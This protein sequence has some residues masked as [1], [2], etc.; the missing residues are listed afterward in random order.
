M[1]GQDVSR[2]PDTAAEANASPLP[3]AV[4]PLSPSQFLLPSLGDN[5]DSPLHFFICNY[6]FLVHWEHLQPSS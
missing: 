1:L 3:W 4:P 2:H 6:S 5:V